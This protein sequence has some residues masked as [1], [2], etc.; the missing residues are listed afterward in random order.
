MLVDQLIALYSS[1]YFCLLLFLLGSIKVICIYLPS[2]SALLHHGRR[3]PTKPLTHRPS[4][5]RVG[6]LQ[7]RKSLF[8]WF[9]FVGALLLSALISYKIYLFYHM[10]SQHQ[11]RFFGLFSLPRNTSFSL[12]VQISLCLHLTRRWLETAFLFPYSP[13]STMHTGHF[14]LGLSYYPVLTLNMLFLGADPC[15]PPVQEPSRSAELF[16]LALV[17]FH[18]ACYF[19]YQSHKSLFLKKESLVPPRRRPPLYLETILECPHYFMEICIFTSTF[20]MI[21]LTSSSRPWL[22]T[23]FLLNVLWVLANLAVSAS[24]CSS[25]KR[26]YKIIPF[27]Y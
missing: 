17:C 3:R 10:Y 12:F 25:T 11:N 13:T 9:Y 6:Q 16:C 8:Q 26:R 23:P 24:S 18:V 7:V 21:F 5:Q 20:F 27:L 14:L 4:W 1:G 2:I 15:P 19:Q 22:Q